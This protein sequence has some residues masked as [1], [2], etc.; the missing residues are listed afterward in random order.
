MPTITVLATSANKRQR[1]DDA[2]A[3][4]RP[5][6]APSASATLDPR[7]LYIQGV[8]A[9]QPEQLRDTIISKS[10]EM[11]DLRANIKQ[12]EENLRRFDQPLKDPKT[13]AIILDETGKARPF[14]PNSLRI[15]CPI[16]ASGSSANEPKMQDL[17]AAAKSAHEE[18]IAALSQYAQDVA[19]LEIDLRKKQLRHLSFRLLEKMALAHDV[20]NEI[21]T[22]DLPDG[23]ALTQTE[24]ISKIVHDVLTGALP[25]VSTALA[26]V[27]GA[28]LAADYCTLSLFRNT[29]CLTKMTEPDKE[30]MQPTITTLKSLL[31][32]L[33]CSLWEFNDTQDRTRRVDAALRKALAIPAIIDSTDMVDLT[34][35]DRSGEGTSTAPSTLSKSIIDTIRHEIKRGEARRESRLLKQ[36]RKNT[37]GDGKSN[38]PPPT[39]SGHKSKNQSNSSSQ[40]APPETSKQT[41]ETSAAT[42]TTN[43]SQRR[44][45]F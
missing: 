8:L 15:K 6:A 16:T 5:S 23:L 14:I 32:S 10:L 7:L 38:H 19:T 27:T 24:R 42:S 3:S 13:G 29:A 34:I 4:N 22:G 31:P 41:T 9:S 18:H 26:M 25:T 30:F 44:N 20:V 28:E 2:P 12:R 21:T 11:L 33:T 17:L 36:L 45:K 43:N 39:K 1:S 40:N 37:S 35:N